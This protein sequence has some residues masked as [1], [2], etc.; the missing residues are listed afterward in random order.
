MPDRS[1]HTETTNI[2]VVLPNN[3]G[4]VIMATPVLEGLFYKHPGANIVFLCEENFSGG[5]E[6]NP[7]CKKIIYLPR[8]TIRDQLVSNWRSGKDLLYAFVRDVAD[9]QWDTVINLSQQTFISYLMPLLKSKVVL[10]QQFIAEGTHTIPDL[11]SQ[12][13]YAI[14]FCRNCNSLHAVDVY[15]RI[16]GVKSHRGGYTIALSDAERSDGRA[17]LTALGIS[18]QEKIAVF[19]PGAAFPSK[20]W[21]ARYFVDLGKMLVA[22]GWKI[23]LTGAK[24][25]EPLA[26]AITQ[27]IGHSCV[28]VAGLTTFRQSMAMVSHCNCCV[29]GDTAQMHAAAAFDIPVFALFGA[30]SPVETGPYGN[31]HFVFSGRCGSMPCFKTDCESMECMKS[32][33]PIDVYNCIATGECPISTNCNVYRTSL[34]KNAD[35]SLTPIRA[36]MH[37]YYNEAAVCIVRSI[38]G[39][40]WNCVSQR[41]DYAHAVVELGKWMEIVSDMCNAL[42]KFEKTKDKTF[43]TMFEV[44]KKSLDGMN[45]VGAFCTAFLNIRLNS[46]PVLSPMDAIRKSIDV[47][48]QTHKQAGKA[49]L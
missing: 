35:Y 16:A 40:H 26:A 45:S 39:D 46:V 25:E 19:Q 11:W 36:V 31:G 33:L 15:R 24:A 14:P 13:L 32:I 28:S 44:L 2:L 21:P 43:I 12:Y 34:L 7:Y 30:T 23:I 38:F 3:L 5:M 1:F 47:C 37:R 6:H 48:W 4:D 17:R 9:L 27:G 41:S 42:M 18:F 49:I 29:T 10:G 20:R 22:D 8:K